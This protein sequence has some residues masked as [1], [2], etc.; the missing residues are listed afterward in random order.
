VARQITDAVRRC[1]ERLSPELAADVFTDGAAMVGGGALLRGWPQRL[2]ESMGLKVRVT[3]EP[4][5]CVMRGL[6][7]ILT[8][9]DRYEEVIANSQVRPSL[10][11]NGR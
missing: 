11:E 3:E 4:L 5:L 9:R 10:E 7:E 6:T 8:H 2:K 1:V